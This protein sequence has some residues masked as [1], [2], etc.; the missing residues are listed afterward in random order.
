MIEYRIQ[1]IEIPSLKSVS[2]GD[3]FYP[4]RVV[5]RIYKTA[6][7]SY[8]AADKDNKPIVKFCS[9]PVVIYY[10]EE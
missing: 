3:S 2:I 9:C 7:K 5:A 6:E 1:S 10:G 4:D 8:V